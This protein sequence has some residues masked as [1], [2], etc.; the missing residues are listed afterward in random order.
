MLRRWET[1][2]Q[3]LSF[4]DN[5]GGPESRREAAPEGAVKPAQRHR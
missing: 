2:L 4:L 5:F 3:P 1:C